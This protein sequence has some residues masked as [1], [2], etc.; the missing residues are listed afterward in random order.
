[1]WA[2]IKCNF[3]TAASVNLTHLPIGPFGD[4]HL[5]P[6]TALDALSTLSLFMLTTKISQP[7]SP[8]FRWANWGP[9]K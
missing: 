6:R 4:M 3:V 2:C 9:K 8:L 7:L 5:M 1:M